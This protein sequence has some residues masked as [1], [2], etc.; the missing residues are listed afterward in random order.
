[1]GNPFQ[2]HT[3]STSNLTGSSSQQGNITSSGAQTTTPNED[4]IF[5][6]F[7]Q[8]ILPAIAQQYQTAQQPV[9]GDAQR[10]QVIQQ[11][12]QAGDAAQTAVANNAARRGTL[13]AGSTDAANTAIQQGVTGK[14]VDFQNQIPFL[15]QQAQWGKTQDL[16][17]LA[18]NFLGR[19]PIGQTTTSN[20]NTSSS[21]TGTQ[22]QN[23]QSTGSQ[24][25]SLM[26]DIGGIAGMLA[27][28]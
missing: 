15:N 9:Y 18:T 10:A 25:P 23:G 16:L 26:S 22:S 19:A 27:G 7:R 28:I 14:I 3:G 13:N 8:S 11:A 1:M 17:G 21:S 20:G 12:N 2:S 6:M 5:S 24:T 4:P